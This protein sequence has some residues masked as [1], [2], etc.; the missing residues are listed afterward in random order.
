MRTRRLWLVGGGDLGE[1]VD[2]KDD[3][4]YLGQLVVA[5]PGVSSWASGT[6]SEGHGL[7]G[8]GDDGE[9]QTT[10]SLGSWISV[11]VRTTDQEM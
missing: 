6:W 1:R 10:V 3:D 2:G 11:G 7:G 4:P 5:G 9:T 8:G